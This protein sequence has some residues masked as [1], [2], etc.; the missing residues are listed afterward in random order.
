MLNQCHE[1]VTT[2]C[3]NKADFKIVRGWLY[4]DFDGQLPYEVFLAHSVIRDKD[5]VLWDITPMEAFNQY[6][7]IAALESEGEYAAF[8]EQGASRIAHYK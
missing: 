5:G 3:V 8:I 4:L 1:N 6:P 7:F 2:W